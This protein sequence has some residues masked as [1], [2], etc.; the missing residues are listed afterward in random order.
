MEG[1]KHTQKWA[2]WSMF[3]EVRNKE[4]FKPNIAIFIE[5]LVC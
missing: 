2:N 1:D 5:F 4:I 3:Q